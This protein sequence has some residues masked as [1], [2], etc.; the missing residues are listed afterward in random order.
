MRTKERARAAAGNYD[1]RIIIRTATLVPDG[2]GGWTEGDPVDIGPLPAQV[3]GLEGREGNE[4]MQT[5]M[6]RPFEFRIRYRD[7]VTGAKDIVYDGRRFDVKSVVDSEE[8][9]VELVIRADEVV[10]G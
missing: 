7:D 4:A 5:G 3:T 9:R 2:G 8:R 10:A 6:Q 1:K